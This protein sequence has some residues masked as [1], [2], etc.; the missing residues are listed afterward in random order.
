MHKT[1]LNSNES[2]NAFK[3]VNSWVRSIMSKKGIHYS[4]KIFNHY[5]INL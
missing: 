2:H 3:E 1:I 4:R 5:E